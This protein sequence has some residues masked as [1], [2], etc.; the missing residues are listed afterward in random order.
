MEIRR[1]LT[2]HAGPRRSPHEV[3]RRLTERVGPEVAP[4]DPVR[5]LEQ[6]VADLLGKQKALFSR[7]GRWPSRWR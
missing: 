7:Q 4:E 3:L 5:E 2:S 6:R 1:S